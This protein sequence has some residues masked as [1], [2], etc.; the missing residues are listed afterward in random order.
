MAPRYRS[1]RRPRTLP[2]DAGVCVVGPARTIDKSFQEPRCGLLSSSSPVGGLLFSE[3]SVKRMGVSTLRGRGSGQPK[4]DVTI[5]P[6]YKRIFP[7]GKFIHEQ[8]G[9]VAFSGVAAK[10]RH[11]DSLRDKAWA[12]CTLAI[13]SWR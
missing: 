4:S 5:P 1:D 3:A 13:Q 12:Q 6:S 2:P 9:R 8:S 7:A 11:C 10:L